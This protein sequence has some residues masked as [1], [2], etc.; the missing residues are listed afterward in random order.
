VTATL[1]PAP[2]PVGARRAGPGSH[3]VLALSLVLTVI[4]VASGSVT[5]VSL[6]WLRSQTTHTQLAAASHLRVRHPCGA[7]TVRQ[8]GAAVIDLTSKVWKT[9]NGPTVS[10]HLSGDT[11]TVDVHCPSFTVGGVTGSAALTLLV[12]AGTALDVS[13][14]GGSVHLVGVSG[15]VVAHSSAGSVRAEGLRSGSV[16]ATSSAGGVHLDFA[17]PPTTVDAESSAGSVSVAVPDDGTAY[18]VNAHTSAG[19][20][21][22]DIATDPKSARTIKATSSAG[23]VLVM[24][25]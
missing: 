3:L 10:T 20:T 5:L 25:R 4:V 9:F 14:A 7:V 8:G 1:S 23:S 19:S 13:S 16:T 18:A 17:V 22:V 24:W 21:H 2:A 11:L 15:T 12:P 6:M